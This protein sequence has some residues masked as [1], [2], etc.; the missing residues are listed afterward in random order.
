[1][2]KYTKTK[3]IRISETQHQTLIK[4]KSYNIDVGK[5]IREAIADKI[6]REYKDLLPKHKKQYC[7]FSNGTI[8]I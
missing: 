7:P 5:F 4:M 1:M 2:A 3:V 6:K 8:E